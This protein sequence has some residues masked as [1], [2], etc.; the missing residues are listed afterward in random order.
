M[1]S[2]NLT[3]IATP[4]LR[5]GRI[6]IDLAAIGLLRSAK[7]NRN[8]IPLNDLDFRRSLLKEWRQQRG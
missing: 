7:L 2:L 4:P 8:P 3:P 1:R 6:I 5:E